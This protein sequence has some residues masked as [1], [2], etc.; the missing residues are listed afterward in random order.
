MLNNSTALMREMALKK[1]VIVCQAQASL[2]AHGE[3]I[4][5]KLSALSK[6]SARLDAALAWCADAAARLAAAAALPPAP[7]HEAVVSV[8]VRH[9]TIPIPLGFTF[10]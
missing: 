9:I 2:A 5:G 6:Y 10:G 4:N 8:A 1:C 3:Y 7:R